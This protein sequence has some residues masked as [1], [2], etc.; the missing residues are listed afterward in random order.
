MVLVLSPKKS[1][2]GILGKKSGAGGG[3]GYTFPL[4]SSFYDMLTSTSMLFSSFQSMLQL[5]LIA[6]IY[7]R[8]GLL[9]EDDHN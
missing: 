9:P 3:G 8:I 6:E 7:L 4:D 2:K 1:L 5:I